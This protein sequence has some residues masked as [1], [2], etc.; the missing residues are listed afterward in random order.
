MG[1]LFIVCMLWFLKTIMVF[2]CGFVSE[3]KKKEEEISHYS[4]DST[5]QCEVRPLSDFVLTP[6]FYFEKSQAYKKACRIVQ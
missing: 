5:L 3:L 4:G 6:G 2:L 1:H